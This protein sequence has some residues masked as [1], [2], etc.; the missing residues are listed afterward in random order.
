MTAT[1]IGIERKNASSS[2]RYSR[3]ERIFDNWREGELA[4]RVAKGISIMS[5]PD[6]EDS[7]VY[8][9]AFI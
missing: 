7:I 9:R 5:S 6:G 4:T 1:A 8:D 2:V 3:R